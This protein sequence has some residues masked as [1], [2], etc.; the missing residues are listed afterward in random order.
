MSAEYGWTDQQIGDLPLARFRQ[1]TAAIQKRR[2]WK[3]REDNGRF[4]WMTRNLA[5]FIAA[6]YQVEG[7]NPALKTAGQL[8]YD[9]IEQ[10]LLGGGETAAG[11][12]PKDNGNGSFERFMGA[13]GGGGRRVT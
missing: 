13:F 5:S 10:S 4:S 9:D 12:G 3:Q 11:G 1:I 7:E 2:F 6:G 8:A